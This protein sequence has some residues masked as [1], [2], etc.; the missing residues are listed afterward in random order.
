MTQQ[1]QPL[2]AD[3][4]PGANKPPIR[5]LLADVLAGLPQALIVEYLDLTNKRDAL[6]A[7]E[8]DA[9]REKITDESAGPLADYIKRVGTHIEK[10]DDA[11]KAVKK[12]V[13]QAGEKIDGFFKTITE[14]LSALKSTSTDR[15][16][17]YQRERANEERRRRKEEAKR[18]AEEA[19]KAAEEAAAREKAAQSERELAGAI[20]AAEIAKQA[21]AD[22]EKARKLAT[23]PASALA[24]TRSAGGAV[25]SLRTEWK[26]K[27]L[28]R[29]TL[30]LEAL[31]P[32]LPMDAMDKAVR[33]YIKAGNRPVN[34]V[35][36]LKGVEI[37]ED[38]K[39]TVR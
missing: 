34:G 25:A 26:F 29:A 27:N 13:L 14:P 2:P 22:A 36:P 20:G 33:A 35:Q 28:D 31:R 3:H 18:A 19:R 32:F 4:Q 30:D 9:G 16:T 39:A 38:T 5:E 7:E 37:Y 12:P 17:G 11:R 24:Q 8:A 15:L 6:Q 1:P 21:E 23:A 10:A